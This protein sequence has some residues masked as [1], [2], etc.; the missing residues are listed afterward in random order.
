MPE[1]LIAMFDLVNRFNAS[2]D[3]SVKYRFGAKF[4]EPKRLQP[5]ERYVD[6]SGYIR[7]LVYHGSGRIFMLV[8]GSV[9]QR[10]MLE[11][12]GF[13]KRDY[14]KALNDTTGTI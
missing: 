4:A 8:D 11:M 7:W 9:N 14:S 2:L 12:E 1:H 3:W 6:C 10:Q 5:P 13:P